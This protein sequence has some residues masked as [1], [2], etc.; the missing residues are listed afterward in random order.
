MR[1]IYAI[2]DDRLLI[3]ATDRV[4][5]FDVVLPQALP[6]KGR[7]L[8]SLSNFWFEKS[9]SL[10]PHHVLETDVRRMPDPIPAHAEELDGRSVLVRRAT[11]L[12]AEFVVRGYLAGSG[13]RDYTRTG[14]VCGHALPEGLLESDRLPEPLFTPSTKAPGGEHDENIDVARLRDIL[15]RDLAD[16]AA[17]VA[18][19]L[20]AF[21]AEFAA[22]RGIILADTK[23]EFGLVDDELV[24]IDEVLTPDSSRY[25]PV[26]DYEPG[27]AQVSFDKQIIRDALIA[28]GWDKQPPAPRLP[29]EVLTRALDRYHEIHRRLTGEDLI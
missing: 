10:I 26:D 19:S 17:Q 12:K 9:A 25:W 6:G 28:T 1:D 24:L 8:T 3:V 20:Y 2:G 15:G 11:P 21:G 13:F 5:A 4:S 27:R 18:M 7:V 22:G 23:F 16:R 29:N 14:T